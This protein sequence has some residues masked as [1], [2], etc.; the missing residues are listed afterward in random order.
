MLLMMTTPAMADRDVRSQVLSV[1]T[2]I[3]IVVDQG[4]TK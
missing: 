4:V 3:A 1:L 2:R